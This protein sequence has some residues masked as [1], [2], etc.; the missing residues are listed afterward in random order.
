M[1]DLIDYFG[2]RPDGAWVCTTTFLDFEEGMVIEPGFRFMDV[3]LI[4]MLEQMAW[5]RDG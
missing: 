1:S 4:S 3:E 5:E 2:Q